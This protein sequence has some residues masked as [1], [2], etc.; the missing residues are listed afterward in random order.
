M[1]KI[2]LFLPLVVLYAACSPAPEPI[3]YGQDHCHTCKMIIIDKHFG[4]EVVTQ[5]GKVYKFDDISCLLGF[6]SSSY[7]PKSEISYLLVIDHKQGEK[8][9]DAEHAFFIKSEAIRSPMASG[10][11]ALENKTDADLLLKAFQGTLHTWQ[12]IIALY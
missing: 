6:Y 8:L 11:M 5:R 12:E 3:R 2:I 9:V 10:V 7:E 4:G 1:K